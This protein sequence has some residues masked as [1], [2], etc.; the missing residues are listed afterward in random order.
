LFAVSTVPFTIKAL[1][2]DRAVGA[3]SPPL[4]FVRGIA[5]GVGLGFGTLHVIRL[6]VAGSRR[7]LDSTPVAATTAPPGPGGDGS[8]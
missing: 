7:R 5:Q 3:A 2:K 8:M 1:H 4:L 6:T